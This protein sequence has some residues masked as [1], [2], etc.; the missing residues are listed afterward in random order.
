MKYYV[1]HFNK[2]V[3]E[4]T[5]ENTIGLI[6]VETK[7]IRVINNDEIYQIK[8]LNEM[9]KEKELLKIIN[10]NKVILLQTENFYLQKC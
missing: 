2:Y 3:K 9:P 1:E 5:D 7:D 4:T 6:L 8:Y 10:E